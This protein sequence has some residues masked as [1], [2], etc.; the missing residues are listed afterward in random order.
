VVLAHVFAGERADFTSTLG[1]LEQVTESVVPLGY[2]IDEKPVPSV[3]DHADEVGFRARDRREPVGQALPHRQAVAFIGRR[4]HRGERG[5]VEP[6]EFVL[7]TGRFRAFGPD[8]ANLWH[9]GALY[10]VFDGVEVR[11]APAEGGVDVE[12]FEPRVARYLGAPF[13]LDGFYAALWRGTPP[14]REVTLVVVRGEAQQTVKVNALD[15]VKTLR[16]PRGI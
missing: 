13:D 14:E 2:R 3:I 10:R 1:R 16:H 11:I 5:Q 8:R 7:T 12:P 15:R 4:A 6:F 9:D